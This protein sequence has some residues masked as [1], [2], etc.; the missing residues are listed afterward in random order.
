MPRCVILG[1]CRVYLMIQMQLARPRFRLEHTVKA[2]CW[3]LI[4]E[5]LLHGQTI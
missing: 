4:L 2:S 1:L 3:L 5:A